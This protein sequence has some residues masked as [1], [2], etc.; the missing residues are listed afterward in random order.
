MSPWSSPSTC[1]P[2]EV[3]DA[4][5]QRA[6]PLRPTQTSRAGGSTLYEQS[7][8]ATRPYG[9]PSSPRAVT[10]HTPLTSSAI[11]F[12]NCC[13][14]HTNAMQ[15]RGHWRGY[16]L[17]ARL[18]DMELRE[19]VA[20]LP[21]V[22]LHVHL[23]GAACMREHRPHMCTFGDFAL[24]YGARSRLL[25]A[26]GNV[27]AAVA[28]MARGLAASRVLYAEVTVTPLSHLA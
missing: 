15:P 1:T 26:E 5:A 25:R 27:E 24:E 8:V 12:A 7:D 10:A 9:S 13:P 23:V 28:E 11:A 2:K 16:L 17:L 22:E 14:S 3:A 6:R 18:M 20:G 4:T 19:W 21:K